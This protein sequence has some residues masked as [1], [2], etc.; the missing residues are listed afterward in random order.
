M[1]KPELVEKGPLRAVV[2]AH[3]RATSST[4]TVDTILYAGVPRLEFRF[5]ADWHESDRLLTASFP[6]SVRQGTAAFERPYGFEETPPNG[7]RQCAQQ[8]VDLSDAGFGMSLLNEGHYEF[9]ADGNVLRM[10]ILRGAR[11]MDPRMDEGH[12]AFRYAL[13]PH[14]GSWKDAHTVH[15]GYEVNHPLLAMQESPHTGVF[16]AWGDRRGDF[17]LPPEKSFLSVT[18]P[19]VVIAVVKMQQEE[20]TPGAMVV[21]LF[22]TAGRPVKGELLAPFPLTGA[23]ESNLIEEAI[24]G[25]LPF[26]GAAL[27]FNMRPRELKTLRLEFGASGHE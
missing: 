19:G 10:G 22:E 27:P 5:D 13:Y 25:K 9:Y 1:G 24:G 18:A 20:W 7:Q 16:P 2:R 21:R 14:A 11:D 26:Q 8:W 6:T 4:F 12:H 15:Q 17:S 23:A 3:Y